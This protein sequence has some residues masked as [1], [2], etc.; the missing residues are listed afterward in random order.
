MLSLVQHEV[1]L[2]EER[3]SALAHMRAH[4]ALALGVSPRVLQQ[5]VLRGE[6]FAAVLTE[7]RLGLGHVVDLLL[8]LYLLHH[9]LH[10]LLLDL[11]VA[12]HLDN[13]LLLLDMILLYL[14]LLLH[15]VVL[16]HDRRVLLLL[17]TLLHLHR[18]ADHLARCRQ[19]LHGH[20]VR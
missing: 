9:L 8:V 7:V 10:L 13:C 3:L 19:D 12:L 4:R 1:V 6:S 15:L 2:L 14:L 18:L 11:V 5:P 16:L 17:G 20:R